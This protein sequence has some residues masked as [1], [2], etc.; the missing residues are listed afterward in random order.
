M[1]KNFQSAYVQKPL[2]AEICM[3]MWSLQQMPYVVSMHV[4]TTC[5]SWLHRDPHSVKNSWFHS[6]LLTGILYSCNTSKSL[7][8]TE[9]TS[10]CVC[11]HSQKSRGLRSG[12]HTG[13][14]T[15]PPYPIHCSPKVWFRCCLTMQ[16]KWGGAP[17]CMNH[18][19]CHWWMGTCSKSTGKLFTKTLWHTAPASLLGK[20]TGPKSWSPKMPTQTLMENRCWCLDATVVWG[21][22]ST[23]TWVLWSSQYHPLWI[24]PHQ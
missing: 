22:S 1:G 3:I 2:P 19:C 18:M 5:S 14:L 12:V 20:T 7:I 8:S 21:L 23:Q 17:S 15:G 4:N 16:R 24:P 11:P 13:Q 6:D 10:L 9:Y